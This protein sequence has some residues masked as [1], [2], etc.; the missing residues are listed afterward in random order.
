VKYVRDTTGRLPQRPH[1]EPS[2][3]D[4]ECETI[5]FSFLRKLHGQIEF[6]VNTDDLTKLIEKD[7]EDLD[8]YADLSEF[9]PNVEGLTEFRRY[10]RPI[11][12]INRDL[13]EARNRQNRLRTTLTH[14]YG[15]VHFHSCLW[16]SE[17]AVEDLL[18][19]KDLAFK[20]ICK[21]DTIINA[22]KTDW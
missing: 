18:R 21:R 19:S 22:P 5:I 4:R 20:I 12:K 9:G 6:P 17:P 10:G 15:H 13:M 8:L 7:V 11:V 16:E 3:L 2:E 14:E 1:Y